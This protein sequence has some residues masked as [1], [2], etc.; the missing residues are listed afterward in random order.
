MSN[1]TKTYFLGGARLAAGLARLPS[2]LLRERALAGLRRVRVVGGDECTAVTAVGD[3]FSKEV[4]IEKVL[5]RQQ[6]LRTKP[7]VVGVALD[8][9]R[10]RYFVDGAEQHD[11]E[12][13]APKASSAAS[14]MFPAISGT[15]CSAKLRLNADGPFK[16]PLQPRAGRGFA[17]LAV[18]DLPCFVKLNVL[19][20][21][22]NIY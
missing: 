14:P 3:S 17:D 13:Q 5:W 11:L 8:G 6:S 22:V 4:P 19:I 15:N 12:S 16:Y 10:V 20:V 1:V 9:N 21:I 7:M 18:G 2:Q